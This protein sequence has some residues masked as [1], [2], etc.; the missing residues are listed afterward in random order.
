MLSIN[1]NLSS[2]I[3]QRSMKQTT[4]LL[5]QAIERMT[6]GYKLNHSKDNAANFNIVTNMNTKISAYQVAEDNALQGLEMIST[7]SETLSL[8]EDKL[9]KMRSLA[10]QAQNGTYGEKSLNAINSEANAL[11]NEITRLNERATY[12]GIIHFNTGKKEETNAGK[13][14]ELNEQGFLQDIVRRDTLT[15]TTVESLDENLEITSGTYSITTIE[16]LEK[17]ADMTNRGLIKGGEFVLGADLDLKDA[18]YGQD[19]GKSWQPIGRYYYSGGWK[20]GDFKANFDGNGYTISNLYMYYTSGDVNTRVGLFGCSTGTIK[21]LRLTNVNVRGGS[22]GNNT[23]GAIVGLNDGKIENCSV[24]GVVKGGTDVTTG[25]I[26]GQSNR[27]NYCIISNCY[28]DG[29]VV[30]T[31][32]MHGA[33]GIVGEGYTVKNC[34]FLGNV[35]GDKQ[36]GGIAGTATLVDSSSANGPISGNTSVGGISCSGTVKNSFFTGS[37]NGQDKVGGISGNSS[38]TNCIVEGSVSGATNVGIFS[39]GTSVTIQDGYYYGKSFSKMSATAD[40]TT[41]TVSTI[42]DITIPTDYT[43]QV[44]S[45]GDNATSTVS[46]TTYIEFGGLKDVLSSGIESADSI[47]KIDDLVNIVSLKQTELGMMEQRLYSVL[48]EISIQYENLVS[49]RSTL[50]DADIADVSSTY[51]QQQILQQASATLMSTANQS[52]SIALSLI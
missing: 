15:M 19:S 20:G 34:L 28:F 51:I 14:L 42:T 16:E 8:I 24:L 26:A 21:N 36:V 33:G 41:A 50:R 30:A 43:L 1:T 10:V 35:Q 37:V 29:D 23:V 11:L 17:L 25:G 40:D 3:T 45:T 2:F 12:N 31:N 9:Q 7:T 5:N 18:G 49:S 38:N 48:D 32:S 4:N 44:G 46:C 22:Y 6:T 13:E 39:G 47:K 52:A 27:Y